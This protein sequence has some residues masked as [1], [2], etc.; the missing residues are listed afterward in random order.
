MEFD[1]ILSKDFIL[2]SWILFTV[3]IIKWK[4]DIVTALVLKLKN[5]KVTHHN[6]AHHNSSH[7]RN[8]NGTVT[9]N[10]TF[11]SLPSNY[12]KL[13]VRDVRNIFSPRETRVVP[14][15]ESAYEPTITR[16]A[17]VQIIP[18]SWWSA[19]WGR[20]KQ[21]RANVRL[22]YRKEGESWDL[23]SPGLIS[24]PCHY[25]SSGLFW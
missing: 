2:S 11:L 25:Q 10:I 23:L 17:A 24:Q 14:S 19:Q 1:K 3:L 5:K 12:T 4:C 13:R 21:S 6:V 22:K 18:G 15:P 8:E 16:R 9:T 7:L 20:L